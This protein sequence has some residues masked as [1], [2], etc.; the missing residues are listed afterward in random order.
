MSDLMNPP[1][2]ETQN[3]WPGAL[4]GMPAPPGWGTPGHGEGQGT[5]WTQPT[6]PSPVGWA[7]RPDQPAPKKPSKWVPLVVALA[8]VGTLVVGA[9]TAIS[10]SNGS[11]GSSG[12]GTP[13]V[14]AQTG[15]VDVTTFGKQIG[16]PTSQ[17][18]PMGAGTGMVLTSNGEVLTNNHVVKGAW[19]IQVRVPG[20]SSYTATVVGVDPAHDVALIQ[21]QNA[22]G[23]ATISPGDSSSVSVG[24]NVSGIGNALGRGG[25]PTVAT[26]DVTGLNR[27][28]TANDPDGT[29]ERLTGMIQTNAHIQPG[30]S[31]GAL[32]N[33]N[34]QVIGMITA[35]TDTQT[36]SATQ[37]SVGFAIPI[38]TALDVVNQIQAGGGGTVLMGERGYLGVG[39]VPI[40]HDPTAAA[41]LGVQSGALVTQLE[42]NGP[43]AQAGMQ[44]PAMI[45][46]VDGHAV[47]SPTT[48]GPLLHVHVPGESAQV[49][50]VDA[51]GQHTATVQLISGPAV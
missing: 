50:W 39:V 28:I 49:T 27:T 36:T 42:P 15:I 31:G 30:D 7:P 8:L 33:S 19:K 26:G 5:Q 22:S 18:E 2:D 34:G 23:M 44:V 40:D 46:A 1:P 16:A 4:H 21:L 17:L 43:A 45:T 41:Q 32:V 3:R 47:T 20:G 38:T 29:S 14:A 13:G 12:G 24:Q 25:S 10:M 37:Q 9:V 51:T 6:P 48:L 35:G 11:T